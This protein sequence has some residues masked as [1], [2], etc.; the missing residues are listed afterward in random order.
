M[1]DVS[2]ILDAASAGDGHAAAELLLLVHD[3]VRGLA[4]RGLRSSLW[5]DTSACSARPR[6][7]PPPGRRSA[8]RRPEVRSTEVGTPM[9]DDSVCGSFAR[10]QTWRARV[11]RENRRR[12]RFDANLL[13]RVGPQQARDLGLRAEVKWPEAG[14]LSSRAGAATRGSM[15]VGTGT[16]VPVTCSDLFGPISL[17]F[18]SRPLLHCG[19]C[20]WARARLPCASW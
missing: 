19:H 5:A 15:S 12:K 8:V 17:Q 20:P 11:G 7:I 1:S 6:G 10:W 2:G 9:L 18:D 3:E 14:T 4:A 16:A 13:R